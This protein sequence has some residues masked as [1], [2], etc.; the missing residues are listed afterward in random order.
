[1]NA[2]EAVAA[3]HQGKLVD[4]SGTE[5]HGEVRSALQRQAGK[6][7]DEDQDIYAWMALSEVRRL[8]GSHGNPMAPSPGD[9]D[10]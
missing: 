2:E 3:V 4:C 10:G 5:Y 8:D 6:W 1:M 7:I 9:T